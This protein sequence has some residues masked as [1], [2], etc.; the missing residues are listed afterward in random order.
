MLTV[1]R[2]EKVLE[3]RKTQ[4]NHRNTDDREWMT[5]ANASEE[6][7]AVSRR[8]VHTTLRPDIVIWSRATTYVIMMEPIQP[9]EVGT[10]GASERK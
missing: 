6:A 5:D 7:I 9:W 2:N 3:A 1:L 8:I 10:E 4:K